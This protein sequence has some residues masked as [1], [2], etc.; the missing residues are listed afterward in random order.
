M[1]SYSQRNRDDFRKN[2]GVPGV[3]YVLDNPGLRAGI[4]KIGCS[5]NSGAVRADALNKDANTG[6]P[7]EFRCVFEYR[8]LDCGKAE[9]RVHEIFH[10]KRRGKFGRKLGKNERGTWGQEFFEVD[11]TEAKKTI[12][13]VCEAVDDATRKTNSAQVGARA[14]ITSAPK[15]GQSQYGDPIV[16]EKR[17]LANPPT[18]LSW[19]ADRIALVVAALVVGGIISLI[20]GGTVDQ[21]MEDS[22]GSPNI[23]PPEAKSPPPLGLSTPVENILD[24]YSDT[25]SIL[26]RMDTEGLA[27]TQG[28]AED[29]KS[30]HIAAEEGSAYVQYKLGVMYIQGRG[31][32]RDVAEGVKWLRMA[33]DQG[34]VN[35][36]YKLGVMYT[37]GQS[38]PQDVVEGVRWLRA[39]ADNGNSEAL[40]KLD[41]MYP[42]RKHMLTPNVEKTLNEADNSVSTVRR[43][44]VAR[45]QHERDR[46]RKTDGEEC[47]TSAECA[48]VLICAKVN[49]SLMQCMS[50]DAALKLLPD[51]T[52]DKWG[53][54]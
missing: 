35:A 29:M 10:D 27:Y 49:S 6:T 23:E 41:T 52:N 34:S 54:E 26:S 38:V 53:N 14:P 40:T 21:H 25:Q 17:N 5:R 7:G 32:S 46:L 1:N 11:L 47:K 12:A 39:A 31:G 2:H 8:T 3:V 43:G 44:E 13:Q 37:N 9:E 19:L 51:T 24:G 18:A 50:S 48:G 16:V 28:E 45:E 36:Q 4:Y 15:H 30:L 22:S 33:A 42:E 20:A